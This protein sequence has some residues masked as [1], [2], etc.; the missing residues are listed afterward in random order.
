MNRRFGRLPPMSALEGF[1]AAARL[2][3]FSLAADELNLSQSAVSHQ[4]KALEEFFGLSLFNR[5]GRTVE[6]TVAGQDFL[7]TATEVLKQLA[8]GKRRMDF[9]FRPGSVVWG[10]SAAF[11][12][13]WL[14]PRY[15]A[16]YEWYPDI[17]P[18][19]F[20]SDEVYEL[21]T[22]EVDLAIWY[23]D[24]AWPGVSCEKLFHEC[25]TPLYAANR[26]PPEMQIASYE[27][28]SRHRILHDERTDDWMSWCRMVEH[29]NLVTVQGSNFSDTGLM[30][31]S[32][33][34]GQ[35]V[36]LGS[37][38]LADELIQDGMLVQ[39]F[40]DVFVTQEAYYL[41]APAN[42]RMRPAVEKARQW[43]LQEAEA[44]RQRFE[45]MGC[46]GRE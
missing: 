39:P 20:T 22:Q 11:A 17:E 3:S 37:L 25:L 9:Y 29:Q 24:G 21:E 30:L 27:D 38:I 16:M 10:A 35:G 44:F 23:G 40:D 6:L 46:A 19:L 45:G 26:Y 33:A 34:R 8:R 43:L 1:E 32:A 41:V 18:W 42:Q 15:P 31:E 14:L 5:V 2:K 7:D 36:A 4:I 13:K 28:L 12:G